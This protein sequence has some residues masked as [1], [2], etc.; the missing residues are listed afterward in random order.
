MED[1]HAS[2]EEIERER[3]REREREREK[4]RERERERERESSSDI[5]K[6]EQRE[7]ANISRV[8]VVQCESG[9]S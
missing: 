8:R 3:K 2:P 9:E 1:A 7:R 5:K 4:E 6:W